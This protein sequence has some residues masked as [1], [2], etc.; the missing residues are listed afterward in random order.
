MREVAASRVVMDEVPQV[1]EISQTNA[2]TEKCKLS[3]QWLEGPPARVVKT[4]RAL[5]G[6]NQIEILELTASFV[7]GSHPGRSRVSAIRSCRRISIARCFP[8]SLHQRDK[9]P[10]GR[11]R[12]MRPPDSTVTRKCLYTPGT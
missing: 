10:P 3:A 7:H 12:P 9:S 5:P 1:F 4:S 2:S 8:I 11:S 6:S